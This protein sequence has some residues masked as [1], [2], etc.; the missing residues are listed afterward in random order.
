MQPET[1]ERP[2]P[3]MPRP[4]QRTL[5]A[6]PLSR[7][8]SR[9]LGEP[10]FARIPDHLWHG[11]ISDS[12]VVALF[13]AAILSPFVAFW[14]GVRGEPELQENRK[15]AARPDF[16]LAN[17]DHWA[18][19]I[20]TYYRDHFGFRARL[21]TWENTVRA[22]KLGAS[23]KDLLIGRNRWAF[24]ARE[25]NFENHMGLAPFSESELQ[26]WKRHL[27][28]RHAL[29][30]ADGIKYLFVVAPDKETIYPE[31]LP[32]FVERALR[33][34]RLS[35]LMAYLKKT[36]SPVAIL[37]LHDLLRAAKSQGLVYFPQDTHWNGR[38]F[39]L[40]NQEIL[41]EVKRRW[42]PDLNVP[43]LAPDY[44]I[45]AQP[46]LGGEWNLVG[47]PRE[48]GTFFSEFVVR[49]TPALAK[50]ESGH[51]LPSNWPEI[52]ESWVRPLW[53]S[54]PQGKHRVVVIHD[55]FMRTGCPDR[56]HIPLAESFAYS[57]FVG[58]R[59]DTAQLM[60]IIEREHPDLVIQEL[61]ERHIFGL[62]PEDP[63][64]A[65]DLE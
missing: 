3:H 1:P 7:P 55:S 36:Q 47:L 45:E 20:D 21:I 37:P 19:Q 53:Y 65:F 31:E 27:E 48:N 60:T 23:N 59:P 43:T 15:L 30:A 35:Q 63:P 17:R 52:P 14:L 58:R 11:R 39:F 5:A 41:R 33:P 51:R 29:L 49:K 62:P 22:A 4:P 25:G 2:V 46:F 40:A 10:E 32:A 44:A 34:D 38:G 18:E 12:A 13:V 61:V 54:Q 6:S 16:S 24:Y 64:V 57:L 50:A 28:L 9:K 26:A 56:D 42:F 8:G